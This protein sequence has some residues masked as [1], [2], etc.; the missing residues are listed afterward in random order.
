MGSDSCAEQDE[1]EHEH[2]W[3]ITA[4]LAA[5]R[6]ASS[7]TE[8]LDSLIREAKELHPLVAAHVPA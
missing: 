6:N 4:R 1:L 7:D 8:A 2:A 3:S 5:L